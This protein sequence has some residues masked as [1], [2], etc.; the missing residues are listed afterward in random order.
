MI[1]YRFLLVLAGAV[2]MH[3]P[4]TAAPAS[5]A[6]APAAAP[7]RAAASMAE[8]EAAAIGAAEAAGSRIWRHDRAAA[9]VSDALVA[10]S[11]RDAR[12]RGWITEEGGDAIVVTFVDAT[13]AALYRAT[14]AA[15]GKLVGGLTAHDAPV[16]LSPFE[17]G[18]AAARA[19]A[20][21]SKDW[22]R[23]ANSINTVVLPSAPGGASAWTVYLLPGTTRADTVP[24][25]GTHRIE[26]DDRGTIVAQRPFTRTCVALQ[27]D[28][29]AVGLVI[30][31]LLDPTPTEAHVY[32]SLWAGKSL[33][34]ATER[35]TWAIESGKVSV[36]E[37]R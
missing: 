13:P 32:W 12:V 3:A 24:I 35:T 19:A 23:C 20:L 25:G 14:V 2:F 33:Y 30:S 37:R 34:V 18:A 7:A 17:A 36:V 8:P 9:V 22:P 11:P 10:R 31:H 27:T 5:S 4:T 1:R 21:A 6:A 26:T 28:P 15:D 29:R 16:A